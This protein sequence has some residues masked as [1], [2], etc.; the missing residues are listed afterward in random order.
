MLRI[1]NSFTR[2]I[3]DFKTLGGK[4]VSMYSCGPTVYDYIHIGNLRTFLFAD[5][6][7]RWLEHSGYKVKQVMNI[8]D[9]GH[10]LHDADTGNDKVE[11]AAVKEKVSPQEITAKYTEY[12]FQTIKTLNIEPAF[13]YPKATEN[14]PQMIEIIQKLL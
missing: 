12:F 7:R 6:L 4:K 1:Y 8:T 5:I 2:K 10:M 13:V 3:E 14:V 9:V 11:E